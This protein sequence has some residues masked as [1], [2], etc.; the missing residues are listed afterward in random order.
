M[1]AALPIVEV[2]DIAVAK[3]F[4]FRAIAMNGRVLQRTFVIATKINVAG[5]VKIIAQT[6]EGVILEIVPLTVAAEFGGCSCLID[7]DA[8]MPHLVLGGGTGGSR[9]GRRCCARA[10]DKRGHQ[11]PNQI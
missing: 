10:Q 5:L 2:A 6:V 11:R 3:M 4:G 1:A 8:I 9:K 7:A